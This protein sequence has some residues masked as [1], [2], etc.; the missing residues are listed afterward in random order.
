MMRYKIQRYFWGFFVFHF[1]LFFAY[2]GAA[3][4][5]TAPMEIRLAELREAVTVVRDSRS[6][7]YI[8][9]KNDADLYFAQGY[10]TAS[11]RLWQMDLLRRVAAG[12]S[13]EIFGK[14]TLEEDKRWRRYGFRQIAAESL[15]YLQPEMLSAL[16]SY[17]D[18]VNAYIASLDEK[19]LPLEFRILQYRPREWKPADTVIIGKILSDALSSTYARDILRAALGDIDKQK[20]ADLNDNTSPYDVVLFGKDA[21]EKISAETA[22]G[23]SIYRDLS[24]SAPLASARLQENLREASL[25]RIGLYAEELAASNNWVI[26]GKRTADGKP[27]LAND[28]HLL[29]SAPGI[30][31]LTH[32]S[33]PKMRVAG[34]T[35]PGVPGIVLGHNDKIAWGATNVGPDVQDIYLETFN[36]DGKYNTPDGWAE[37]AIRRE[38]IR[39]RGNPLKPETE[40]QTLEVTETRNGPI[41]LEDKGVRYS[42]KWTALDPKNNEFIAFFSLNRAGNWKDF[43]TALRDYGGAAQ[44]FIYADISGNIGWYAAGKIPI[45]RKGDG[46]L[47]YDGASTD[48]DWVGYIPFEELPHLYNPPEGFIVTANQRLVGTEYKYPQLSRD[49]APPWRARRLFNLLSANPKSTMDSA[50]AAQYDVYNIPLAKFAGEIVKRNAASGENIAIIKDWDGRMTPDSRAALLVNEIRNCTANKM[51]AENRPAP[52]SVI[53]ERVLHWAISENSRRWLPR[54]FADYT[55]LLKTC[56]AES[57]A[58]FTSRYG[59]NKDKWVWGAIA[60]SRFPHPLS[61]A[62]LLGLRFATPNVPIAGSGQTPNVASFVSMRHLASPGNWDATRFVIPLGES[63]DPDSDHYADQFENWKDGTPAIFPFSAAAVEKAAVSRTN[64]IPQAK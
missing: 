20:L 62:P 10:V 48:G 28:P 36:S 53:R 49:N 60:Q 37:P 39:V 21:A 33:T 7:P 29:A 59:G 30:W 13:A 46:A 4:S 52:S 40:T 43:I 64:L 12:E 25:R 19:Q 42:L 47:P 50:S 5:Q 63:G 55:A 44:N 26:S 32:L 24:A 1:C 54:E 14:A 51:A 23:K 38:E 3:I 18:G 17:A 9:A 35:F 58:A 2:A 16:Q 34:V 45:R 11:D 6:I 31:Y 41:V 56:D 8:A 57:E 61:S 22:F 15:K 27:L